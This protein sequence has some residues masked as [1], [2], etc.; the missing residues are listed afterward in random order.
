MFIT[1]LTNSYSSENSC[2]FVI[3]K[4]FCG[5]SVT[6]S[7]VGRSKNTYSYRISHKK[8]KYNSCCSEYKTQKDGKLLKLV[9]NYLDIIV[10]VNIKANKEIHT[11]QSNR[12]CYKDLQCIARYIPKNQGNE[13]KIV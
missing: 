2:S 11:T 5:K 1:E 9:E 7:S 13:D 8:G 6:L 12:N 10:E 4:K 3:F